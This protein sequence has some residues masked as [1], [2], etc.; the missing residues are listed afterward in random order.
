MFLLFHHL[1]RSKV[2][3]LAG[4]ATDGHNKKGGD[5]EI[6][7]PSPVKNRNVT[8][9]IEGLKLQVKKYNRGLLPDRSASA[10]A[11]QQQRRPFFKRKPQNANQA[12]SQLDML[13]LPD[14]FQLAAIDDKGNAFSPDGEQIYSVASTKTVTKSALSKSAKS[15]VSFNAESETHNATDT[16]QETAEYISGLT[17]LDENDFNSSPVGIDMYEDEEYDDLPRKRA[18]KSCK[19][20][21]CTQ[22]SRIFSSFSL[23]SRAQ[24]L[25]ARRQQCLPPQCL[26]HIRPRRLLSRSTVFHSRQLLFA[27]SHLTITSSMFRNHLTTLMTHTSILVQVRPLLACSNSFQRSMSQT[28]NRKR[29][30][31]SRTTT[32]SKS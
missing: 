11:A 25:A 23:R 3:Q 1:P 32:L 7:C 12:E 28:P 2:N 19:S 4:I 21:I 15:A 18:P 17:E 9:C 29:S 20:S 30:F 5:G 27:F 14:G 26:P 31:E 22:L 10:N 6:T 16:E 24:K 8:D 13:D